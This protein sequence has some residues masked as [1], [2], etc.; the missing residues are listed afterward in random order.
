MIRL[1]KLPSEEA[2]RII[3]EIDNYSDTE[4]EDLV[5]HWKK[6]DPVSDYD[7]SYEE[8]RQELLNSFMGA[9]EETGGKM[10]YL[11]DLRVGLKLYSLLPVGK[12]F[13]VV[14]AN[15]DD[16][17]RYISVKV[18]PDITYLRY[19]DPEKAVAEASG[20]LNHKRFYAATRRIWLKTLWWY[21][22]LSWQGNEAMTFEVLKDNSVDNINKL[23]ETPGRGY[24][25]E[26]Y[27]AM[28]A[29]YYKTRP[30][31]S[32]EFASVTKMNNAK[33]VLIEPALTAGGEKG[34]VQRLIAELKLAEKEKKE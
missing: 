23:I 5:S 18:M 19:P 7:D 20:R 13:S 8:F 24:R 28:M 26:L 14:Q 22:F 10:N 16:I 15:D 34:Y 25:L 3:T 33:C 32:K 17:W 2:K 11:L 21:V 29:E 1:K 30:H 4:F 9:L 12:D 31:T 6:Y 27:R